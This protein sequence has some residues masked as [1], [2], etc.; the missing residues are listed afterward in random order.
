MNE[1]MEFWYCQRFWQIQIPRGGIDCAALLYAVIRLDV[2]NW[3][4]GLGTQRQA[5]GREVGAHTSSLLQI[6]ELVMTWKKNK[7][8]IFNSIR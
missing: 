1:M 6:V 3:N 2:E 5:R 7:W 4:N 8:R